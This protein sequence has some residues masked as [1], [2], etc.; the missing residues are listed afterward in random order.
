VTVFDATDGS[1]RLFA[2]QLAGNELL[3]VESTVR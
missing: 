3:F 2:G 1:V